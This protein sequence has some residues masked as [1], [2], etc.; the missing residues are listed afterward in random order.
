TPDA[1]KK[2]SEWPPANDHPAASATLKTNSKQPYTPPPLPPPHP[3]QCRHQDPPTQPPQTALFPSKSPLQTPPQTTS[4]QALT[5]A[6]LNL[7]LSPN[8]ITI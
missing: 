8:N 6:T 3:Q 7:N 2:T 5:T 4:Q 1:S